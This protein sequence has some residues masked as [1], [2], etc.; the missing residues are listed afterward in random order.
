MSRD[1]SNCI[2]AHGTVSV[3]A[4]AV[5]TTQLVIPSARSRA[6]R[7]ESAEEPAFLPAERTADS[8]PL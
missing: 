3:T 2:S 5:S 4:S 1:V 8:S 7:G 6:Q